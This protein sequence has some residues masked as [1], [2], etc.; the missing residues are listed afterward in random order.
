LVGPRQSAEEAPSPKRHQP[1]SHARRARRFVL[2][3]AYRRDPELLKPP[4]EREIEHDPYR[5]KPE[6]VVLQ[7]ARLMHALIR[8]S[9]DGVW[10]DG[11]LRGSPAPD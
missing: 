9:W 11:V 4:T 1:G 6:L 3:G 10:V 2:S 8:S 5:T 7:A